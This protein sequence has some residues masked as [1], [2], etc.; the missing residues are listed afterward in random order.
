MQQM[1]RV[2]FFTAAT[3]QSSSGRYDGKS[4]LKS[5]SMYITLDYVCDF[6][7]LKFSENKTCTIYM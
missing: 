5:S 7:M 3:D 4:M 2:I 1:G 6:K